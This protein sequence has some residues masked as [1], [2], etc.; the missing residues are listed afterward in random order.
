MLLFIEPSL[1]LR[2]FVCTSHIMSQQCPR[3]EQGSSPILRGGY[4]GLGLVTGKPAGESGL[5]RSSPMAHLSSKDPE[6][7]PWP[8]TSGTEL[9]PLWNLDLG[10]PFPFHESRGIHEVDPLGALH[11]LP[12]ALPSTEGVVPPGVL[13]WPN[14]GA[15]RRQNLGCLVLTLPW[16]P[17][18]TVAHEK[19][20]GFWAAFFL[21][22][23][24]RQGSFQPLIESFLLLKLSSHR[25]NRTSNT[26]FYSLLNRNSKGVVN[27]FILDCGEGWTT[28]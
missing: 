20:P 23:L 22:S 17:P 16:V 8:L 18:V 2:L 13:R 15:S 26:T 6:N 24:T 21:P 12:E 28:L 25:L 5:C 10:W 4:R 27:I 9:T 11:V 3:Q 1:H 19:L 7:I 14:T